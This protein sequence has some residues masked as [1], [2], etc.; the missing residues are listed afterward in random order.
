[1]QIVY[2]SLTMVE[3]RLHCIVIEVPLMPA[4]GSRFACRLDS[5]VE[6]GSG[7]ASIPAVQFKQG[8]QRSSAAG[9]FLNVITSRRWLTS[10]YYKAQRLARHAIPIIVPLE[11]HHL[12]GNPYG[13]VFFLLPIHR[14]SIEAINSIHATSGQIESSHPCSTDSAVCGSGPNVS[15]PSR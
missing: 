8:T 10:Y 11:L 5:I 15:S 4:A 9:S 3:G 14:H 12:R 6:P 1:M 2:H 7:L 13:L